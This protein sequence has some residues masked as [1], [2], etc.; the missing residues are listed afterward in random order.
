MVLKINWNQQ[1]MDQNWEAGL[2]VKTEYNFI[3]NYNL[4]IHQQELVMTSTL[5][6]YFVYEKRNWM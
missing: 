2:E 1:K 4:K 6:Q 5:Q 3:T